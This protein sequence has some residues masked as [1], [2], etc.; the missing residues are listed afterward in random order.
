MTH[1][2]PLPP[3]A[4]G[5]QPPPRAQAEWT[6]SEGPASSQP[7]IKGKAVFPV[8]RGHVRGAFLLH[9]LALSLSLWP[10]L[11]SGS[12]GPWRTWLWVVRVHRAGLLLGAWQ[13][14]HCSPLCRLGR[15]ASGPCP[16]RPPTSVAAALACFAVCLLR[17]RCA[18]RSLLRPVADPLFLFCSRED[19]SDHA[20]HVRQLRQH[21]P[22]EVLAHPA[23]ACRR[24]TTWGP[25]Q[26]LCRL[27]HAGRKGGALHPRASVLP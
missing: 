8:N 9:P 11:Q 12:C 14:P 27:A 21:I 2:L 3:G 17:M 25:H 6:G 26:P 16:G 23:P 5:S 19:V 13:E 24:D 20:V 22:G 10:L 1:L 18:Q 7:V 15:L 4:L